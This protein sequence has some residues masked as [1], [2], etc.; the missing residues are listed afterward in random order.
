MAGGQEDKRD[1]G[2]GI[3]EGAS[4]R[5]ESANDVATVASMATI[6]ANSIDKRGR[7]QIALNAMQMASSDN[8]MC[9][10]DSHSR[11]VT[12]DYTCPLS[13][14]LP[15]PIYIPRRQQAQLK[16]NV[17]AFSAHESQINVSNLKSQL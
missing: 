2:F 16:V 11:L 4:S 8:Q 6:S 17:S 7:G 5:W 3:W 1:V 15:R 12:R 13:L 9:S 14:H 10:M